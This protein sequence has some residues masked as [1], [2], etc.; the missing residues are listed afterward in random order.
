MPPA[1]FRSFNAVRYGNIPVHAP[2]KGILQ[3]FGVMG[4][5]IL[6]ECEPVCCLSRTKMAQRFNAGLNATYSE[7][8]PTGTKDGMHPALKRRALFN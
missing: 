7:K 6:T 1:A 4:N 5:V 2:A 8:V 3:F